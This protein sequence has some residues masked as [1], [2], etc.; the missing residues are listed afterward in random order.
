[1]EDLERMN[2]WSGKKVFVTGATGVIGLNLVN[3]LVDYN[4]DV[5]A[6]V[7][8]TVPKTNLMSPWL[9][10]SGGVT[11]VRGDL[12]DFDLVMRSLAEYE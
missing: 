8:D 11:L 12:L 7:R 2:F 4:A 1:M 6:L 5:V 9:K 10:G 3:Q